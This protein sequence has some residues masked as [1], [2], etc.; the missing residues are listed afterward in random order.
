MDE[1]LSYRAQF[2]VLERCVYMVS[3]SLGAMPSAAAESMSEFVRLWA[4]RSIT[5]WDEWLEEVRRA[6]DRIGRIIGAPPASITMLPNVSQA[7]SVIASCLEYRPERNRIVYDEL[8]F[9]SVSYV[10]KAEERRGAEVVLVP[11][12]DKVT[13][14]IDRL[15]DAI[16]ERTLLVPISHVLFRSSYI[17]DLAKIV[18]KAR[19]VGAMV[20]ADLYQSAGTVPVDVS[21]LGLDLAC[22]GSVKWLCGGPGASYLYVRPDRL[23]SLRPRVTGWFSHRAPFAFDMP[24]QEYAETNWRM[25]GGTPAVA[26]MYQARAGAEMIGSIGVTAIRAKSLRQ[27]AHL[28][29]RVERAGYRLNSP[30]DPEQ[31]GGTVCFDFPRSAEVA[32]ELN[33]RRFFCDHRPRRSGPPTGRQDGPRAAGRAGCG[34][35]VS[36]HFYSKDEEL[37]LFMDEVEKIRSEL[38]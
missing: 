22:G 29:G 25:I 30:A 8:N 16:D 35:R 7:Q 20:M 33:R 34:I 6:G 4:E 18:E 27:T 10:W 12:D 26:C 9:P 31:R 36:P 28:L 23:A 14:A 37:D 38:G 17:Q 11:S 19:A 21:A 2:P 5:A 24:E 13:I 3:H 32:K 1:L 15:L